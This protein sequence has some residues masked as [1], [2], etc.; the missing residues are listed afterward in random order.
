MFRRRFGIDESDTVRRGMRSRYRD[1]MTIA[2]LLVVA[3]LPALAACAP[4]ERMPPTPNLS[5]DGSGADRLHALD[6]SLQ[7]PEIEIL[8]VTDRSRE[9]V[10][11]R[12]PRY[13]YGRALAIAYGTAEVSLD[14][15]PTWEELVEF[16]GTGNRSTEWALDLTQVDEAG[17]FTL[18]TRSLEVVDGALRRTAEAQA[19]LNVALDGL[20]SLV[21]SRL[22][23]TPHKDVYLY[24]HGFNNT[25][26]D[27]I[28]R[29][30]ILWQSISRQ[31]VFI[32][33]TWPA[34]SGG[35]RGYFYDRESG[36]FTSFH[37][38]ELIR[39][40]AAMPEI[41]RLH[42]VA[43]SR[44]TDVAVTALR[45]LNIALQAQDLDPQVALK[46]ETLM[47]AAPDLDLD[48]FTR[49]FWLENLG[50]LARR[51]VIYFS[52][53][54]GAIDLSNWLFRSRTRIGTLSQIQFSPEAVELVK[55][56]PHLQ[57][58]ECEVSGHGTSHAYVFG[59]PAALS[60]VVA[61]L[62]DRLDAGAEHGRPLEPRGD[63]T[64]LLTNDYFAEVGEGRSE[65]SGTEPESPG[66]PV[67]DDA[68]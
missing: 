33:Y 35:L 38:R 67:G 60:D 59:H 7:T 63:G 53:E 55:Q 34:G 39:F 32:A 30:A 26:Y 11:R 43:H 20:K 36:E 22:D 48:V 31:G 23:R 16:S 45:E 47:L 10:S 21:R 54:D 58:I 61:V 3:I 27:A 5:R 46:L 17:E 41:E 12:G 9:G 52:R 4:L 2:R 62:R 24:V 28:A 64:W 49:G 68:P 37:L 6:P 15:A 8:Y 50:L 14:P 25:F 40:L 29:A 65:S 42:L 56:L 1:G 18:T 13:G 66:T 51:S 19:K 44:G 57:M